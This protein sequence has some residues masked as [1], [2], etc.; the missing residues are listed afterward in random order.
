[1]VNEGLYSDNGK[2][3][4]SVEMVE[5]DQPSF[6]FDMTVTTVVKYILKEK[7][8]GE[9]LLNKEVNAPQTATVGDAFSGVERLKL[10]N[11][12]SG[13]KNIEE[14]INLLSELNIEIDK[15]SMVK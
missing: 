4:L 9:V 3:S 1:L 15:I 11:E 2:Y 5:I 12:G 10:A 13:K 6:G 7:S 14:L 8:S